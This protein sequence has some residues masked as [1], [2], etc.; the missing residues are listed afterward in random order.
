V[1]LVGDDDALS[2]GETVR[3]DDERIDG[4]RAVEEPQRAERSSKVRERAVGI[5]CRSMNAFENDLLPST[6]AARASGPKTGSLRARR[7]RPGRASAG[8][9]GPTTTRS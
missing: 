2:R 3:L 8:P 7:R 1:A 4:V 5:R 9:S 6:S